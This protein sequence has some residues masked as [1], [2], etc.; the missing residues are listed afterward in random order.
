M[1]LPAPCFEIFEPSLERSSPFN[2]KSEIPPRNI[3][4]FVLQN[5]HALSQIMISASLPGS[6]V[7]FWG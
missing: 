1:Y 3:S 6:R 4:V 5:S 7:P 2:I